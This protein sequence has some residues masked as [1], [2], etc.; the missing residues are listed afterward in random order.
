M[1]NDKLIMNKSGVCYG[2]HVKQVE[3]HWPAQWPWDTRSGA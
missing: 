2:E 1:S 3:L